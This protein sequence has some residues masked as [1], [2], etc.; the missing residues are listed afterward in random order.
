[1][2]PPPASRGD[3]RLVDSKCTRC[4]QPCVRWEGPICLACILRAMRQ[5]GVCP[6]CDTHR[7][8]PGRDQTG[9]AIC[10]D[11]AGIH[12]SF[13]CRRCHHEGRLIA[14]KL[15]ERCVLTDRLTT[16][17]DDGTGRTRPELL[18]LLT[19]LRL[20]ENPHNGLT[21]LDKPGTTELLTALARA[22]SPSPTRP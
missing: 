9:R 15:C 5:R 8:L 6:N 22:R 1:M 17:L 12:R 19:T 7:L 21:W 18:P 4:S 16:L 2:T 14:D 10:R 11:C 3:T 20:A 13:F